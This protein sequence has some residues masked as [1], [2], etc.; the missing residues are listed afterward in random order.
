M[1]VLSCRVLTSNRHAGQNYSKPSKHAVS[2]LVLTRCLNLSEQIL[3]QVHLLPRNLKIPFAEKLVNL[4]RGGIATAQQR[5]ANVRSHFVNM[6][7]NAAKVLSFFIA[8]QSLAY[9]LGTCG[10]SGS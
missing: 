6:V 7:E 2:L 5:I 10:G 4:F 3:S 9:F 1:C 8:V